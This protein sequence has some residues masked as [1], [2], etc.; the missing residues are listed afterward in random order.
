MMHLSQVLQALTRK[1]EKD[2]QAIC[3]EV[4]WVSEGQGDEEVDEGDG[5][6]WAELVDQH[7]KHE[8]TPV[9]GVDEEEDNIWYTLSL[10]AF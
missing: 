9:K 3:K 4:G 10:Y 6:A 1:E 8:G 5:V 2:R 7:S